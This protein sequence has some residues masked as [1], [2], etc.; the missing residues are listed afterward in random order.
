MSNRRQEAKEFL[1]R[2]GAT[3]KIEFVERG[4]TPSWWDSSTPV[5]IY[6][7]TVSRNGK[8][9]T[10]RFHDSIFNTVKDVKPDEYDVLSCV[11][12]YDVGCLEEFCSEFGYEMYDDY[13]RPD[14]KVSKIY[15]AVTREVDGINRVFGDVID[16]LAEICS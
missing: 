13:G 11:E 8:S 4:N 1:K 10:Y 3:V 16:E 5:N 2:V 12:K 7:V 15:N 9:Y 14:K 6:K